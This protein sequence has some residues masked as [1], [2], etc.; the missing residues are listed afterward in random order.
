MGLI[1]YTHKLRRPEGLFDWREGI[2][3]DTLYNHSFPEG[4]IFI[5][6]KKKKKKC[7]ECPSKIQAGRGDFNTPDSPLPT[8]GNMYVLA[9]LA[10]EPFPVLTNLARITAL[11][12]ISSPIK[13]FLIGASRVGKGGYTGERRDRTLPPVRTFLITT[14]SR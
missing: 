14:F 9:I 4:G 12:G 13:S 10:R 6:D 11:L 1:K 7:R 8:S 2:H 5:F 3:C